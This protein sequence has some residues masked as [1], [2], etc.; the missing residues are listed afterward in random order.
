[1]M[2]RYSDDV[3]ALVWFIIRH[4]EA[5]FHVTDRLNLPSIEERGLL[6]NQEAQAKGIVPAYPGGSALTRTLD[7]DHGLSDYVFLGFNAA[8]VMPG[9]KDERHLRRPRTLHV[10]PQIL[11]RRG[12]KIALGRTNRRTET[13]SVWRAAQEMDHEV[14]IEM[15]TG[16]CDWGDIATWRIKKV[17]DYEVLVPKRVPQEYIIKVE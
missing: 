2:S 17:F 4:K 6:S 8:G 15:V 9:H 16:R 11:Y 13:F 5:L 12:V 7:D 3:T 14:F 10:D 1:M